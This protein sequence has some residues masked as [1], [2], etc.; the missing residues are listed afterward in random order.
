MGVPLEDWIKTV[1]KHPAK[2]K[3]EGLDGFHESV[4]EAARQD[5]QFMQRYQEKE[6]EYF[7]T[8]L[9]AQIDGV[10]RDDGEISYYI[11]WLRNKYGCDDAVSTAE[12]LDKFDSYEA[13]W[14]WAYQ[15]VRDDLYEDITD[16]MEEYLLKEHPPVE[17]FSSA[18]GDGVPLEEVWFVCPSCRREP[19]RKEDAG[20]HFYCGLCGAES[21]LGPE[22][23]M[24]DFLEGMGLKPY[25]F[26]EQPAEAIKTRCTGKGTVNPFE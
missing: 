18:Y 2:F 26:K 9:V 8:E 16:D 12:V 20:N 25:P 14:E 11:D 21:C 17:M 6:V 15:Q 1:K 22:E 10:E 5:T 24:E 23:T 4:V 13:K 7:Y 19:A 3:F